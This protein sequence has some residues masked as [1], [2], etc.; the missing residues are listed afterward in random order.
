[1]GVLNIIS[2]GNSRKELSYK[3]NKTIKLKG[4]ERKEVSKRCMAVVDP[5]RRVNP[6]LKLF[7][8]CNLVYI[9][10]F[11]LLIIIALYLYLK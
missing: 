11:M 9:L 2:N 1:M 3:S 6:I 5:K 8:F 10:A 7:E 4:E